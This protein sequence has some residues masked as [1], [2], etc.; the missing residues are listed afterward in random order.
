[1]TAAIDRGKKYDEDYN[2]DRNANINPTKNRNSFNRSSE[3]ARD[4]EPRYD[5]RNNHRNGYRESSYTDERVRQPR[6]VPGLRGRGSLIHM[7]CG[8][9]ALSMSQTQWSTLLR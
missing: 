9:I 3:L 2:D 6:N 7:E 8:R 4:D 5:N 1:M